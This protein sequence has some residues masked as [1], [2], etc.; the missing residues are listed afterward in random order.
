MEILLAFFTVIVALVVIIVL[1]AIGKFVSKIQKFKMNSRRCR[2]VCFHC[3]LR[4]VVLGVDPVSLEVQV[5]KGVDRMDA[6]KFQ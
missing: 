6:R 4:R 3:H 5:C 2:Y 1:V